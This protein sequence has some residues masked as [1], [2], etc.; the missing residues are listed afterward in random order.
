MQVEVTINESMIQYVQPGMPA[1]IKPVGVEGVVLHGTVSKMNRYA[2]PSGWRQAN[3]KEYKAFVSID[4]M[5]TQLRSGMTASVTI[6]ASHVSDAI[7]VPVQAIYVHGRDRYCFVYDEAGWIARQVDCGPTNDKFFIIQGGLDP[8]ERIAMNP[9]RYADQVTLP[10]L[11]QQDV[12]PPEDEQQQLDAPPQDD[13][14]LTTG[15]DVESAVAEAS[16]AGL[17]DVIHPVSASS[18][19]VGG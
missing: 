11:S 17:G 19:A 2:E 4:E 18:S 9:R 3:V 14:D 6:H 1:T 5:V 13:A 15:V 12:L 7:Q 10:E 16:D 8:G